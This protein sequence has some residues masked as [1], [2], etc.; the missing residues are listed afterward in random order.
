VDVLEAVGG[1]AL[2]DPQADGEAGVAEAFGVAAA[3]LLEGAHQGGGAAEL[4]EGEEAQGVAEDDA[5][6]AALVGAGLAAQAAEQQREG[7]EAEVSLGLAAAGGEVD[8]VGELAIVV[9]GVGDRGEVHEDEGELEGAPARLNVAPV[10]PIL[11]PAIGLQRLG[12]HGAIG[13][14]EGLADLGVGGEQL[15]AAAD[16]IPGALGLLH[17]PVAGLLELVA[18][19][20][21]ALKLDPRAVGLDQGGQ[22]ADEAGAVEGGESAHLRD[23]NADLR[24]VGLVADRADL[25]ARELGGPQLADHAVRVGAREDDAGVVADRPFAAV[26]E[27]H[28][29]DPLILVDGVLAAVI[30]ASEEAARVT[31]GEADLKDEV[32]V[33]VAVERGPLVD[34]EE[35]EDARSGEAVD[36][37]GAQLA[38]EPQAAGALDR[39]AVAP[40]EEPRVERHLDRLRAVRDALPADLRPLLVVL[41]DLLLDVFGVGD[42][43]LEVVEVDARRGRGEEHGEAHRGREAVR[44]LGLGVAAAGVLGLAVAAGRELADRV[45]V[46][47]VGG[48]VEL[49]GEEAGEVPARGRERED[50]LAASRLVFGEE[51]AD[52]VGL[53]GLD[54]VPADLLCGFY[55]VCGGQRASR[56]EA[57]F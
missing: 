16:S 9:G 11:A 32:E 30:G 21:A 45:G 33:A 4:V 29:E 52:E 26:V 10:A 5:D 25:V 43:D 19:R 31:E 15:D 57:P 48:A 37:G 55:G 17:E 1:G 56:G 50:L 6:A 35:A 28:C 20:F 49:W 18:D 41:G 54:E 39:D 12:V 23:L 2:A 44:T 13:E 36:V 7:D 53:E 40:A 42:L 8:E 47:R 3:Q 22:G 27:G 24:L 14:R 51:G 38:A 34:E 46:V